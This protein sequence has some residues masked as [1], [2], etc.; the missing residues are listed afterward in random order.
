MTM[1]VAEYYDD[2]RFRLV[3]GRI[4]DPRPG[5]VQVRVR[6]VGI[7]GSDLHYFEDGGFGDFKPKLPIVLGH[8]PTGEVL[9]TGAGVTG[10]SAGDRAM[11]EPAIYCYHCEF[12]RSGRHNVCSNI[13]F[14][15]TAPE[16]G[17]FREYANIPVH[18]LVA[19]P[20][21]LDWDIGT[22]FEPLSVALHSLRLTPV[23]LGQ[24]A[25]VV[26]TGPIGLLTIAALKACGAGRVWASE[27]DPSR[28]ELA[29][30]AGA[31]VVLDPT[32][33][34]AVKQVLSDTGK[35]G[36]DL[37]FDCA[38]KNTPDGSNTIGQCVLAAANAGRVIMTAIPQGR[39]TPVDMHELRRKEVTL[40][41]VRRSNHE[42][43]AAL[44]ML[45]AEPK[46]FAPI[47]THRMPI[48]NIQRAFEMLEQKQDG[49]AKIVLTF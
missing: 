25:L 14:F 36:V 34:D 19:L 48:E 38:G 22:L 17:Y 30:M 4:E 49:A 28:R 15:S 11:L 35:R 10:W 5:E 16:P 31:D 43:D 27:P 8:E 7:C 29:K 44:E 46:R 2:H 47:I 13:K 32:Q 18:N 3:E 12:C 37:A 20:S 40:F 9:K 24:T 33:V 45:L 42:T 23:T 39:A 1:R 21:S 26:G 6:S 41:N